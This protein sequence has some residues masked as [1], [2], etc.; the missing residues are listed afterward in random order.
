VLTQKI[1]YIPREDYGC[2]RRAEPDTAS[3][4]G[5]ALLVQ[6]CR[7]LAESVVMLRRV[8]SEVDLKLDGLAE[9]L[10]AA[11]AEAGM[12]L[13]AAYVLFNNGELDASWAAAYPSRP[14]AVLARHQAM[15]AG[16]VPDLT[17]T[18]NCPACPR[19]GLL[20][21]LPGSTVPTTYRPGRVLSARRGP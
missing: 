20:F 13:D 5:V 9:S 10:L 16:G 1:N 18:G 8:C 4:E 17:E 3:G 6:M 2:E 19:S 15:V 14:K 11:Q 21:G 7:Q 12:A